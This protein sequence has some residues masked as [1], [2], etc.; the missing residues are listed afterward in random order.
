MH[1]LAQGVDSH[2]LTHQQQLDLADIAHKC[3]HPSSSQA[4]CLLVASGHSA[5]VSC[6]PL[7]HAC[8]IRRA[9]HRSSEARRPSR[10]LGRNPVQHAQSSPPSTTGRARSSKRLGQ[11]ARE[12]KVG[13]SGSSTDSNIS[14]ATLAEKRD[15]RA[16]ECVRAMRKKSLPCTARTSTHRTCG[17]THRTCT[18]LSFSPG[19]S[20]SSQ[21]RTH[22]KCTSS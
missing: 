17:F 19:V 1:H 16:F 11:V 15:V 13:V 9:A 3:L 2:P 4:D 18:Q 10:H 21:T 8:K 6:K 20:G 7:P 12:P 14:R 5:S 22:R